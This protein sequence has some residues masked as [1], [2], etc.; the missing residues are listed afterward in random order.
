MILKNPVLYLVLLILL[1]TVYSAHA[2]KNGTG[3]IRGWILDKFTGKAL[4]A[5]SISSV[6][7][8]DST[9]LAYT[10]SNGK[11]E[12]TLSGLP[13]NQ[14]LE[15]FVSFYG[16]RDTVVF[17]HLTKAEP[18]YQTWPLTRQSIDLK[19]VQIS[20]RK[21]P[22]QMRN[23]T[24]E[25]DATAFRLLPNAAVK[26]LLKK[27]PGVVI[28][29][30]GNITVNGKK[31][32]RIQVDGRDFFHGN[33]QAATGNLPGDMI[34]K[35]QVMDT[36]SVEEQRSL[37]VRPPS[38]EV[39][40]NLKLKKN[41]KA[42]VFGNASAAVGTAER[43]AGNT[44]LNSFGEQTRLS[45]YGSAG[46]ALNGET[47]VAVSASP[48]MGSGSFGGQGG[49]SDEQSAGLNL[50][51]K[52]GK[53]LTIDAN[54]N[55]SRNKTRKE[56]LTDRLNL[57]PDSSFRNNSNQSD[58]NHSI[59]HNLSAG[60]V[61]EADSFT[62]LTVRPS[63]QW[64]QADNLSLRSAISSGQY[65]NTQITRNNS[66]GDQWNFGNELSFN[67]STKD[68]R[69][70]LNIV[71]RMGINDRSDQQVNHSVNDFYTEK[72][73]IDQRTGVRE[74]A[75]S[76]Y[77]AVN[78]SGKLGGRFVAALEYTLDRNNNSLLQ[79]TFSGKFTQIDSALSG[80]NRNA[81]LVQM[82]SAQIA[83][84]GEKLS[85]AL[86]AGM[87][88]MQQENRLIWKDS[89]IA[90]RQQ[91]FSPNIQLNYT[92]GQNGHVGVGYAVTATAPTA[93]QLSPAVDNSNPL[94]IRFGNPAL[95]TGTTHSFHANLYRFVPQKSI[96][97]NMMANGTFT[98][99]QVVNDVFYDTLGRQVS[100]FRNVSGG[101]MLNLMARVYVMRKWKD[102]NAQ[103]GLNTNASN[104]HEIG[105][106]EKQQN[107]SGSWRVNT[108]L[109]I[110]LSWKE[111]YSIFLTAN[112]GW[113]K[114]AYSLPR[115]KDVA[116]NTQGYTAQLQITA[117]KRLEISCDLN[118]K[119][120]SQIPPEFQRSVTVWNSAIAYR[121][122]KKEQLTVRLSVNDIFN[123]NT[124]IS[125][126]TGPSFVENMQ[127]NA[128]KRYGMLSLRYN[129]NRFAGNAETSGVM[130]M[131]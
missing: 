66:K 120:N 106:I 126:T 86:N 115:L 76:H 109:D 17:F 121:F 56:T 102:W 113:N 112:N 85:I 77:A 20:A 83:Y 63:V 79:E 23:D 10:F 128:L 61:Y 59:N 42:G 57:L 49:I 87:R 127:V 54:Y 94:Y 31:A 74:K 92:L 43:Y 37:A 89:M 47:G 27:L 73:T 124:N 100:T 78:L 93:E 14:E 88:F 41:K 53:K 13:L 81:S 16:F 122:L 130:L 84:K 131:R 99:N 64:G 70:N 62:I 75:M 114:T 21:P 90:I 80:Y 24:L 45:F 3:R 12:F 108:Y 123:G 65:N 110:S 51:T 118:Y 98:S 25:F 72:D 29:Q 107:A 119:Y 2:Q 116:Y 91:Q 22:F 103:A 19:E 34:E 60:I 28:D 111:K 39:T 117:I 52:Y 6:G 71:W 82:P 36:K 26:D 33:I 68:R 105:F 1:T 35:V 58:V 9:L 50:N 48:V 97:M 104:N 95:K 38:E 5:A 7:K 44:S 101:R 11:G 69:V 15:V 55:F 67:T 8:K 4:E 32:N 46:N 129:F 40:I 30:Q 125:R 96:G 18:D